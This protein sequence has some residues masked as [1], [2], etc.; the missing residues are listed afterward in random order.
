MVNKEYGMEFGV[1]FELWDLKT[2]LLNSCILFVACI[3]IYDWN[4][5]LVG[6][7][8]LCVGTLLCTGQSLRLWFN[9]P[10]SSA[11]ELCS[12]HLGKTPFT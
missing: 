12:M 6:C 4:L 1:E 3:M 9:S 10:S 5:A 11:F 2:I 8:G 7:V